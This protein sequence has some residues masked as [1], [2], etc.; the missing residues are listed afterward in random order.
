MLCD[1]FQKTQATLEQARVANK[2]ETVH[3]IGK[4]TCTVKM[5]RLRSCK[6]RYSSF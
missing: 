6:V 5:R 3:V 1:N 2:I 4:H